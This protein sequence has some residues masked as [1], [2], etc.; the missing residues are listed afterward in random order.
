[1]SDFNY[2]S[3]EGLTP[4]QRAEVQVA[5]RVVERE[6]M[7]EAD[8]KAAAQREAKEVAAQLDAAD[9]GGEPWT[10]RKA[11]IT[12]AILAERKAG[13]ATKAK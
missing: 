7:E 6:E 10:I 3:L 13:W 5:V 8:R 2:K 1:M 12:A 9:T 4:E 11:K